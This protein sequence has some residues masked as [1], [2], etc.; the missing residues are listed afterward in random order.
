[1]SFD[2]SISLWIFFHGYG[3]GGY[4]IGIL[5]D[6]CYYYYNWEWEGILIWVFLG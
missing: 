2:A 3:N 6:H 5:H 1:M 4:T